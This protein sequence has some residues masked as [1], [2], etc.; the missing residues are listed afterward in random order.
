MAWPRQK[1]KKK[2][3]KVGGKMQQ[4]N[5]REFIRV[6]KFSLSRRVDRRKYSS[7]RVF[8][9]RNSRAGKRNG[10]L[11]CISGESKHN[12]YEKNPRYEGDWGP[13]SSSRRHRTSAPVIDSSKTMRPLRLIILGLTVVPGVAR[14]LAHRRRCRPGGGGSGGGGGG[15]GGDGDGRQLRRL[16]GRRCS[17]GR[18]FTW[19]SGRMGTRGMDTYFTTATTTAAA[20]AAKSPSITTHDAPTCIRGVATRSD[21]TADLHWTAA[22]LAVAAAARLDWSGT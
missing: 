22:P 15:G 9:E 14:R 8:L 1:K 2:G 21:E 13:L 16:E 4:S 12:L 11:G 18:E 5:S 19:K 20:A 7:F 10:S 17:G 3:K 6:I